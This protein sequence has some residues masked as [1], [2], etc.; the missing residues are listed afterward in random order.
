[1]SHHIDEQDEEEI[2]DFFNNKSSALDALKK[3][4]MKTQKSAEVVIANNIGADRELDFQVGELKTIREQ[5]AFSRR[6]VDELVSQQEVLKEN[7]DR[8][9]RN[10]E[11]LQQNETVQRDAIQGYG[12]R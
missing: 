11:D 7:I 10:N 6:N 5:L 9:A 4:F 12:G 3:E 1:M 2:A 8:I